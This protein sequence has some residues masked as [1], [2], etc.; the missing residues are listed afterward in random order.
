M[1]EINPYPIFVNLETD[2]LSYFTT[3]IANTVE[4]PVPARVISPAIQDPRCRAVRPSGE[5]PHA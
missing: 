2:W 1:A 5:M 4:T 3:N